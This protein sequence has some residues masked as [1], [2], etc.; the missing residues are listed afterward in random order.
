MK[1]RCL[2]LLLIC[3]ILVSTVIAAD[4]H[5]DLPGDINNDC[6]TDLAD[7]AIVASTWLV[8]CDADNGNI[9][10]QPLDLDGDGFDAF[11][12]C[13][14]SN[15]GVYPGSI[16]FC[17]SID[18]NCDGLIDNDCI[19]ALF[20][21]NNGDD[22]NPG[23]I[24]APKLTI[25]AAIDAS[26]SQGNIDIFVSNGT[27]AE[28][29]YLA[30]GTQLYGGYSSNFSSYD[31]MTYVTV[32]ESPMPSF[33]PGTVNCLNITTATIIDGFTIY[34]YDNSSPSGSS[35]AIYIRDCDENLQISNNIIYGGNGGDGTSGTEGQDGLD[36]IPGSPGVDSLDL[37]YTYGLGEHVCDPN[38]QSAGGLGGVMN[39]NGV[40][41][42]GGNGGT[43]VCPGWDEDN[44]MTSPPVAEENGQDGQ[45][46]GAL[47]G[48]S[49]WDVY[50]AAFQC[51]GYEVYNILDGEDGANG[52]DGD[53]G[54]SGL[55]AITSG[56][57]VNN[58]W[59]PSSGSKGQDGQHGGGGAGGG[60]GAG[61]YVHSSCF[62]Y[63]YGYDNLGGS[64]GG[65]GSGACAGEGGTGGNSGGS[66]FGIFLT[67]SAPPSSV[68]II[69]DNAIYSGNGGNG[70]DGGIGSVGGIGGDGGLGG[71]GAYDRDTP[72]PAYPSFAGGAGGNG[73]NGGHGAGGGGGSGGSVYGI[74]AFGYGSMDLSYY[75]FANFF[76]PGNAGTGGLGG[77]SPGNP[78]QAGSAGDAADTNF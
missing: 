2:T 66:S 21:S 10:C 71:S 24:T 1:T 74:F 58:L 60:S 44:L 67:Y 7:V 13:N 30:P 23:S 8:D 52:I 51:E 69:T 20:V 3:A 12:D 22:S 68:P 42:S 62:A 33:D 25:Q 6:K 14:D 50:Q 75:K 4:C 65:G 16:E 54:N 72:D 37:Y 29:I 26:E 34:S 17:D 18:N 73:G 41:T 47:G 61:A 57:V 9:N 15:S 38:Y 55:G 36:G 76:N 53:H 43:S 64:G 70:G 32:I 31:P 19:T 77:Y 40:N 49:G 78:G 27:Y 11:V 35:F 45:N 56:S 46:G 39:C 63:L 28:Q 48:Q 5:F 59:Q